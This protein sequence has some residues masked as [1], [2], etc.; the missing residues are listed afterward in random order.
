MVVYHY[1][2]ALWFSNAPKLLVGRSL[3]KYINKKIKRKKY[4]LEPITYNK[5]HTCGGFKSG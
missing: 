4:E 3:P 5:Q 1:L 2:R